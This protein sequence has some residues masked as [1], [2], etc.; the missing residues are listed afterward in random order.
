M[1]KGSKHREGMNRRTFVQGTA[2]AGVLG[3]MA[4]TGLTSCAPHQQKPT[5]E[6]PSPEQST[7]IDNWV[8]AVSS[9][10]ITTNKYTSF[11]EAQLQDAIASFTAECVVST[12][13]EDG[14]PNVA[15]F[16][17]AGMFEEKY[18]AFTWTDNQTKANFDRSKL[19]MIAFDVPNPTA[20]TKELRHQGAIVKA[21]LVEDKSLV[22]RLEGQNTQLTGSTFVE[23]VDL[24]PVG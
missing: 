19:G 1:K 15:I 6:E 2:A 17:P 3:I 18:I 7:G 8:D 5:D 16:V 20:E 23:I 4:S 14:T 11:S 24:L 9:A 13:N 12:A 21:V 22:E 10:S